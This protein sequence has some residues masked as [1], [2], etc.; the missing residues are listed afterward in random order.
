MLFENAFQVLTYD[1]WKVK[2]FSDKVTELTS[3]TDM[4]QKSVQMTQSQLLNNIDRQDWNGF[5]S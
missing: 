5:H 2:F 1:L 3:L 4:S